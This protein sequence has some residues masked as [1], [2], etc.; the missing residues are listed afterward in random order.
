[1]LVYLFSFTLPSAIKRLLGSKSL[2]LFT[3]L[4]LLHFPVPSH[5]GSRQCNFTPPHL[6]SN[7]VISY[8]AD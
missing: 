6:N 5:F 2:L 4:K 8:F 3:F 1:M 7:L